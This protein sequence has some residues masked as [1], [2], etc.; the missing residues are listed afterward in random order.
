MGIILKSCKGDKSTTSF[1][2]Q[3]EF[4]DDADDFGKGGKNKTM[5]ST[6]SRK[7]GNKFNYSN[8]MLL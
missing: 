1:I 5:K 7:E 6:N 4:A 8:A 3:A 2:V